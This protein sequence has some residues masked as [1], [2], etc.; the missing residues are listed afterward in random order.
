M[1]ILSNWEDIAFKVKDVG[2]NPE[3]FE[4]KRNPMSSIQSIIKRRMK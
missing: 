3:N 4:P 2:P 1:I